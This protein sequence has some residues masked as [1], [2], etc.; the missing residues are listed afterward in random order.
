MRILYVLSNISY[1]PNE[2]AHE[3]TLRIIK[4]I[5]NRGHDCTIAAFV[6][7]RESFDVTKFRDY[8]PNVNVAIVLCNRGTYTGILLRNSL[9]RFPG[10]RRLGALIGRRSVLTEADRQLR[11]WLGREAGAYDVVHAEGIPLAPIVHEQ[12]SRP[13]I[14]S[15]VDAWSMRQR[16]L[17]RGA[18]SL[19]DKLQR[20]VSYGV[21]RF[22]E[23]RYLGD[24]QHVHVVS[25]SDA[26]YLRA[27]TSLESV[28]SIPVSLPG[29]MQFSDTQRHDP[30]RTILISGDIRVSYVMDGICDFLDAAMPRL[31]ADFGNVTIRLLSRAAAF[32]RLAEIVARWPE[33]IVVEAWV[34]DFVAAL[35]AADIVVL[36]DASGSGLKNRTVVAMASARP[37]VGTRWAFEGTGMRNWRDGIRGDTVDELIA[38]VLTCLRRPKLAGRIGRRGA[39]HANHL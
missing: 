7:T 24:F 11:T 27:Q 31:L 6:V 18:A 16:R 19:R 30:S 3:Q 26:A 39:R 29:G 5:A 12:V 17:M 22:A 33:R 36:P 38:G 37:V 8:A 32:G 2:G 15:T 23:H 35:N 21:A 13:V 9:E 1:P 14:F 34:P 10:R 25:P 28:V 20:L 4:G